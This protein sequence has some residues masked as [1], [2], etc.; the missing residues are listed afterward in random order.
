MASYIATI[1]YARFNQNNSALANSNDGAG[2][3]SGAVITEI[4]EAPTS[5]GKFVTGAAPSGNQVVC[6]TS[7]ET[8][9]FPG[10]FLFYFDA[11]GNPT[12]IGQIDTVVTTTITLTAN[13]IG[14]GASMANK[15]LGASYTLI[16]TNESFF[17]RI[18][19]QIVSGSGGSVVYLPNVNAFRVSPDFG[20]INNTIVSSIVQYSNFQNPLSIAAAGQQVNFRLASRNQFIQSSPGF[21]WTTANQLPK[22]IW[23]SCYPVQNAASLSGFAPSTMY[24]FMTDEFMQNALEVTIDY[25]AE[26]LVDAGYHNV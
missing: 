14:S 17:I 19:T 25:P 1:D 24:K 3:G 16:S 21:Y 18:G 10:Q 20:S 7:V 4:I 9:F 15:E 13:I 6:T 2:D 11:V 5:T 12:L 23:L 8:T 22:Y 26:Y